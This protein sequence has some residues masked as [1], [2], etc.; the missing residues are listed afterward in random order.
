M[1]APA[2]P[3][4]SA[5]RAL[6]ALYAPPPQQ[7]LCAALSALE[8]EI[9]ASLRPGID[10]QVAHARL[11][12]WREECARCAASKPA[13]PLTRDIAAAFAGRDPSI[14][15]GL[16][17]LVD[18]AQ[19][20]LA[21]ATFATRGELTGYCE[22]WAGAMVVPLAQLGA[23][24][25]DAAIPRALG[26]KLRE[27]ELLASLAL[28][29]RA[30]RLRLP[31]DELGAAGVDAASFPPPPWP[32]ALAALLAARHRQLRAELS[33][34]VGALPAS[35]Q[36]ALRALLVWTVLAHLGSRRAER[37]LPAALPAGD[38]HAPLDG[39]R[40]WRA[41]RHADSGRLAL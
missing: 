34:G 16:T 15:E 6:A 31:L 10:H 22:R 17:G 7:P 23:P 33:A 39:W 29:A 21:A 14:L 35:A 37:R 20:D 11:A 25:V 36:P 18:V 19:W 24:E 40:A 5:T 41:A 27:S 13:H 28:E 26:A 12:W 30:G 3:A 2:R 9:G 4:A 1:T 38:H 8:E 32:P